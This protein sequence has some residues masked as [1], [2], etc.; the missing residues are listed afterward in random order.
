MKQAEQ[1]LKDRYGVE[2]DWKK[3]DETPM[4]EELYNAAYEVASA[5]HQLGQAAAQ[6]RNTADR[7]EKYLDAGYGSNRLGE[8]QGLALTV[9]TLCAER[10]LRS[11]FLTKLVRLSQKAR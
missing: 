3:V 10:E 4:G 5:E 7:I 9:D 11:E 2:C 8:V 1:I 6:L